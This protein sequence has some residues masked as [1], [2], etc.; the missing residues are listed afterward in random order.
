MRLACMG[1]GLLTV[2]RR[3]ERALGATL[4]P[5]SPVTLT[6]AEGPELDAA[7]RRIL[8]P[9][10]TQA[11]AFAN[12]H[13]PAHART[14]VSNKVERH[15]LLRTHM[16]GKKQAQGTHT[17]ARTCGHTSGCLSRPA[18]SQTLSLNRREAG[19]TRRLW[20]KTVEPAATSSG[21]SL[22]RTACA[23]EG[24]LNRLPASTLGDYKLEKG[25]GVG[26]R[27][28]RRTDAAVASK[29]VR[30]SWSQDVEWLK[31]LPARAPQRHTHHSNTHSTHERRGGGGG[32]SHSGGCP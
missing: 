26:G 4:R 23:K 22:D 32:G 11:G 28:T 7:S 8:D 31:R 20:P 16:L 6:K 5:H 13:L 17:D 19:G 29:Y 15:K 30:G 12:N 21:A 1:V 3:R 18:T 9:R 27:G 25:G 24:P 14:T 10:G 2:L